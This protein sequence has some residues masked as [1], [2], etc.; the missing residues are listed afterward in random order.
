M[1]PWEID[2]VPAEWLIAFNKLDELPAMQKGM[3]Q[4]ESYFNEM[5]RKHPTFRKHV[6]H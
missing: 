4:T 5:K 1:L 2:E 6:R 3:Q